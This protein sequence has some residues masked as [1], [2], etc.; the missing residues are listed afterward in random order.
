[1]VPYRSLPKKTQKNNNAKKQKTKAKKPNTPNKPHPQ[2]WIFILIYCQN[3]T[4][5]V[6]FETK[7]RGEMTCPN[8]NMDLL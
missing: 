5:F 3:N 2:I 4:V 1:M 8:M 7:E 6:D